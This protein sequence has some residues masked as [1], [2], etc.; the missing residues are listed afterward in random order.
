MSDEPD[1][2]AGEQ[3]QPPKPKWGDPISP[4]RQKQLQGYLDRWE[5]DTSHSK[6]EGPFDAVHLTAADVFWINEY[7]NRDQFGHALNLHLS[8]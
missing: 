3:A 2:Q 7:R 1:E 4:E 8:R 6:H 5:T